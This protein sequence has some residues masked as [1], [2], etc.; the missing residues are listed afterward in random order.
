MNKRFCYRRKPQ[1]RNTVSANHTE[2]NLQ[3]LTNVCLFCPKNIMIQC[4]HRK[5]GCTVVGKTMKPH[6]KLKTFNCTKKKYIL[7]SIYNKKNIEISSYYFIK[8]INVS[9]NYT[10]MIFF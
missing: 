1:L 5:A 3:S 8:E 4:G 7:N 6:V 10:Q 9:I 2:S